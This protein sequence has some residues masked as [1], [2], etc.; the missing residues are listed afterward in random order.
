MVD[1]RWEMS[2][3]STIEPSLH[4]DRCSSNM[5]TADISHLPSTIY[6]YPVLQLDP[7][8]LQLDLPRLRDFRFRNRDRE[9]PI[10]VLGLD[11]VAVDVLGHAQ[12][13]RE[14][15]ADALG[16]KDADLL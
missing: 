16:G 12:R 13:A 2:A 6:H 11:L 7:P 3:V 8:L 14:G 5:L 15:A 9:K 4:R 10:P 1:G